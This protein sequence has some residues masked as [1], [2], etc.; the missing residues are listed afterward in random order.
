M[1]NIYMLFCRYFKRCPPGTPFIID[2]RIE[3]IKSNDII[4]ALNKLLD[5]LKRLIIQFDF[6]IK[7]N[8]IDI[9]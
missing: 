2:N 1:L 8:I 5:I 9:N 3:K 6:I 7:N 4:I